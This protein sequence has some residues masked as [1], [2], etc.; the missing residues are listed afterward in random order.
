MTQ[1]RG[2]YIMEFLH[3]TEVPKNILEKIQEKNS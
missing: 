3:Y 2:N 1:G